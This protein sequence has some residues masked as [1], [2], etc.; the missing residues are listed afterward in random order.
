MLPEENQRTIS[1]WALDTFG[2][3]SQYVAYDRTR[4]E[5][6]ELTDLLETFSYLTREQCAAKINDVA[7]ECADVLITLYRLADVSGFDLHEAVDHKMKIN[8]ARKWKVNPD[9]TGQHE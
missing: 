9:G 3:C 7:N 2:K 8:R 5:F 4:K 6:A 1:D